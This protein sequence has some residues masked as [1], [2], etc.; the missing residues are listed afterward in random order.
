MCRVTS[1][2]GYSATACKTARYYKK[3]TDTKKDP[4]HESTASVVELTLLH[5][6]NIDIAQYNI[7]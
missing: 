4:I 7:Y 2:K 5:I 3:R 1:A 6:G